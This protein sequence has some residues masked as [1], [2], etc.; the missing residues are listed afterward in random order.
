MSE[1]EAEMMVAETE[2]EAEIVGGE[3]EMVVTMGEAEI[4]LLWRGLR[5]TGS[6]VVRDLSGVLPL[7]GTFVIG[8][9]LFPVII[10]TGSIL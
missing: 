3:A 8:L 5:L 1:G 7:L 9:N 4:V 6:L 10:L 2:G